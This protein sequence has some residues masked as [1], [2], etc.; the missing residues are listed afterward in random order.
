MKNNSFNKNKIHNLQNTKADDNEFDRQ[1]LNA[2]HNNIIESVKESLDFDIQIK[3][4]EFLRI[5]NSSFW[6]GA[7]QS[8]FTLN[9]KDDLVQFKGADILVQLSNIYID[10]ISNKDLFS[11]ACRNGTT[12]PTTGAVSEIRKNKYLMMPFSVILDYIKLNNQRDSLEIEVDMFATTAKVLIIEDKA[13]IIY[14]HIPYVAINKTYNDAVIADYKEHFPNLDNVINQIIWSRFASD[15][16]KSYLWIKADSD[17]GKGLFSSTLEDIGA[18]IQLSVKEVEKAFEGGALSRSPSNFKRV[19]V[20]QFNEFKSVKSELKELE[21]SITIAAKFQ[22]AA[23]VSIYSK[24]F[25][26]AEGVDSLAGEHGIEDQ[27]A[28]RFAYME[29]TGSIE[30]RPLFM[31][32]KSYYKNTISTYVCDYINRSIDQLIGLGKD[33][34]TK[35]ADKQL[36][37]FHSEF[38]ITKKYQ[39]FSDSLPELAI[40]IREWIINCYTGKILSSPHIK[41]KVLGW[42]NHDEL[43]LTSP[44]LVI[45]EY[46]KSEVNGP[47]RVALSKKKDALKRLMLVR[48]DD[49]QNKVNNKNTKGIWIQ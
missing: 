40:A 10:L 31:E 2:L 25:T 41:E 43:Y 5:V 32:N 1:E 16:K 34:A 8:L 13:R 18:L 39:K 28:N 24:I 12:H 3:R 30:S 22:L 29:M 42:A 38:A 20:T 48:G 4:K 23:K 11:V 49:K 7:K 33:E 14:P 9:K 44:V 36:A 27:F 26:S 47:E 37:D 19:L 17:W 15:R 6:S 46:I 35:L 45:G 21:N